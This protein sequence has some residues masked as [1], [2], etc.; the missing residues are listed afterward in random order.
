MPVSKEIQKMTGSLN[1][2]RKLYSQMVT[3]QL[4][5]FTTTDTVFLA[6]PGLIFVFKSWVKAGLDWEC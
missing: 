1:T 2:L 6:N 4:L 3:K 5:S